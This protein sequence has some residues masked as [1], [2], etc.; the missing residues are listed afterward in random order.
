VQF[1]INHRNA[2]PFPPIV[3]TAVLLL[4]HLHFFVD[5]FYN[6]L[7]SPA[8]RHVIVIIIIVVVVVRQY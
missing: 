4:L 2:R 5:I 1:A 8:R 6:Y 7:K 3:V